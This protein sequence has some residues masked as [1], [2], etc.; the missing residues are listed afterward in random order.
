MT[1]IDDQLFFVVNP[2]SQGGKTR[3]EWSKFE[4]VLK[5][6]L[7]NNF[8]FK[9]ADGIGTGMEISKDAIQD[10]C[11]TIVSV[12]GE[13]TTNEVV[14]AI[15]QSKNS[16]KTIS[17]GFIRSGT[18]NDFLSNNV[19]DWPITLE[20]QIKAIKRGKTRTI[21]IT[22]VIGDITRF[23][24]NIA[25]AGIG[26]K[27]SYDSSVKRRLQWIK[28]DFRYTLLAVLNAI[29]WK[30][31]PATVKFDH[32]EVEGDLTLFMSGFSQMGGGFQTLPQ[33]SLENDKM[34][35]LLV[36]D[37]SR[38]KILKFLNTVKKGKH[39]NSI[40]GIYMDHSSKIEINAE[41]PI[42]FEIDGEPFSYDSTKIIIEA[43]PNALRLIDHT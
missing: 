17:L 21:P 32:E 16:G 22:K 29:R 5:D 24:I 26:A 27:V 23:G 15:L 18:A 7:G 43:V 42:L 35:Y 20:E 12:G 28:G 2:N 36:K 14:N 8:D 37:F 34:A 1:D 9:L 19:Y 33:A 30:N 39:N 38:L 11:N 31:N 13:G 6:S 4:K 3:K 41:N 40:E 10:G 25:D